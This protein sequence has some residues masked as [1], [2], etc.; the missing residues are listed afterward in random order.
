MF[1]RLS[2]KQLSQSIQPAFHYKQ[3]PA[4]SQSGFTMNRSMTNWLGL[5]IMGPFHQINFI[6][7][8]LILT[9]NDTN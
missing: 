7:S 5:P 3:F 6:I 9:N 4:R 8:D 1:K 2:V